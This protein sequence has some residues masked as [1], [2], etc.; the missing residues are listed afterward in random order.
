MHF[1]ILLILKLFKLSNTITQAKKHYTYLLISQ[2]EGGKLINFFS[3]LYLVNFFFPTILLLK[4]HS[5]CS[6]VIFS[7]QKISMHFS[8]LFTLK[9]ITFFFYCIGIIYALVELLIF[10]TLT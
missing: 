1:C 4:I 6:R 3:I 10:S 8:F 9:F 2:S 5:A 7:N